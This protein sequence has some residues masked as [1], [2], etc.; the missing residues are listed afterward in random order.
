[1]KPIPRGP[2]GQLMESRTVPRVSSTSILVA[3]ASNYLYLLLL[4]VKIKNAKSNFIIVQKNWTLYL[5]DGGSSVY[6]TLDQFWSSFH[7]T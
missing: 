4:G 5:R 1:M 2:A 6:I 3:S 7:R